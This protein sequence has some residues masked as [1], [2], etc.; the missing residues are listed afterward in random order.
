MRPK[1]PGEQSAAWAEPPK[2]NLEELDEEGRQ[3]PLITMAGTVNPRCQPCC[4]LVRNT[5]SFR[6]VADRIGFSAAWLF[7]NAPEGAGIY[8]TMALMT[9]VMTTHDQVYLVSSCG[10]LHFWKVAYGLHEPS[11][12]VKNDQCQRLL[13]PYRRRDIPDFASDEWMTPAY[14][15]WCQRR[16]GYKRQRA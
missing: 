7:E 15:A 12:A 1:P 8:D 6:R 3:Q 5:P 10:V 13:Q 4:T 11:M 14:L 16:E 9:A 2:I